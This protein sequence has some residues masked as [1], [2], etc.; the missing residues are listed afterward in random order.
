MGKPPLDQTFSN[1][2]N[3]RVV[4][5]ERDVFS[6]NPEDNDSL[7]LVCNQISGHILK[8]KGS[9]KIKVYKRIHSVDNSKIL[10]SNDSNDMGDDNLLDTMYSENIR[11]QKDYYEN[12][13]S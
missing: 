2:S 6:V 9:Q 5:R 3:S 11:N 13:V 4:Q 12:L 7:D 10:A 1:G 8:R